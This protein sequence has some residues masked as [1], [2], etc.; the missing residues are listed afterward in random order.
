M[1]TSWFSSRLS[2]L[3]NFAMI[4]QFAARARRMRT[5]A[6]TTKML[7]SIAHS[8]FNTVAAMMAPGDLKPELDRKMLG[9]A[10]DLL[11]QVP[12]FHAVQFGEVSVEDDFL[13]AKNRI[14]DASRLARTTGRSLIFSL[15]F[16]Q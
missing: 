1:S 5:K 7:I 13:A 9:I 2:I 12:R 15:K 8:E 3:A 6:S 10:F 14:F 16:Y 4:Y 11:V